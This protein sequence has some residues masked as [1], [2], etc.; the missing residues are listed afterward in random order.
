MKIANEAEEFISLLRNNKDSLIQRVMHYLEKT[1]ILKDINPLQE[2]LDLSIRGISKSLVLAA[3]KFGLDTPELIF[4]T[5][6]AKDPVS[7]SGQ[8]EAIKHR[9]GGLT[10]SSCMMLIKYYRHSYIDL[11]EESPIDCNRKKK[12]NCFT[13]NCFDRFELGYITE[14]DSDKE[15]A[16]VEES[17]LLNREILDEKNRY[18]TVLDSFFAPIIL[19]DRTTRVINFNSAASKLLTGIKNAAELHCN[20]SV[21]TS[22]LN[23]IACKIQ[24]FTTSTEEENCFE[25]TFDTDTEKHYYKVFFKKLFDATDK[26]Q[27][28]II[29]MQDLTEQHSTEANLHDAKVKA[30][31]ADK[32]KTAFLANMSH[33]IRTPMNA[34]IGFTELMLN[35]KY[36]KNDKDEYLKLIRRS[37]A[38]LLDIIEDIVDI[39]KIESKQMKVKYKACK[40]FEI[41]TDLKA[42]F[43]ETLRRYGT[44]DDVEL[45]LNISKE[46]EGIIFYTDGERLKQVISN[47]LNNAAKF[48]NKGFI[49][50]GYRVSDNSSLF[51]FVRDSGLGIPEEMKGK[52][53]ERFIQLGGPPSLNAGGAGLGLAICKNIVSLLGGSIWVESNVDKGSDFCFELPLREVPVHV[54]KNM[55]ITNTNVKKGYPQWHDKVILI[56]EDDEINFIFLNEILSKTGAKILHAKNGLKAIDF[57]ETQKKIDLI[58]MDMKMPKLGGIEATRYISTIQPNIPII[59]Q[60]AYALDGD[61]AKCI[62]AGC[63]AYIIKPVVRE[64]LFQ[65]IAQYISMENY[66]NDNY[67]INIKQ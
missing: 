27:G 42:V 44:N 22:A 47:L 26:I 9:K 7:Y 36:S 24:D 20:N 29:M 59:A 49:E 64:K 52:I 3:K 46:L 63:C 30:E 60:T 6:W 43:S 38:D 11:I 66:I 23:E 40:P 65:L 28:F 1:D 51:F 5:D 25:T 53:F 17:Q 12:F 67:L 19:L 58:L 56:A 41:L 62:D 21:S 13:A 16:S 54:I 55:D 50:F 37:S 45:K 57:V 34:I 32:L 8:I 48:T 33:E 15:D 61:R 2:S 4:N 10:I 39:A 31:E 35:K 18:L 14:R